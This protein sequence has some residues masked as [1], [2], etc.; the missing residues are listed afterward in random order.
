MLML[1]LPVLLRLPLTR[2]GLRLVA[3]SAPLEVTVTAR[4]AWAL[5]VWPGRRGARRALS[6]LSG[7]VTGRL[8]SRRRSARRAPG[9]LVR[10]KF[11]FALFT[12]AGRPLAGAPGPDRTVT[13]RGGGGTG[14]WPHC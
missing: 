10:F 4:G 9:T 3:V 13:R 7:T 14:A 2:L 11:K 5:G 6:S 1:L 8:R 12:L